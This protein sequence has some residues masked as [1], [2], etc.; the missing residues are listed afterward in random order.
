MSG[1][2]NEHNTATRSHWNSS[3]LTLTQQ[4][5]SEKMAVIESH[6][7]T[8]TTCEGHA[9]L[10]LRS[11]EGED[12]LES[13]HTTVLLGG[14]PVFGHRLEQ[15]VD[16][17]TGY[18][19]DASSLSYTEKHSHIDASHQGLSSGYVTNETSDITPSWVNRTENSKKDPV[20]RHSHGGEV[21]LNSS[22]LS[23]RTGD[24]ISH[25]PVDGEVLEE[26]YDVVLNNAQ[27]DE[28]SEAIN[29]A[30]EPELA[31]GPYR[32]SLQNLLKK[33]QEHRRRQR[34]LRNQAKALKT[35]E[36]GHANEHSL[37]DKENEGC[38]SGDTGKTEFRRTSEN[39][40]DD[41]LADQD[42]QTY[43]QGGESESIKPC[44]VIRQHTDCV[45]LTSASNSMG[46]ANGKASAFSNGPNIADS[47][48]QST[49]AK[50]L[51]QSKGK[52]MSSM[53][54]R[55]CLTGNKKFKNVP[56]PKFCL[57]PVRSKKGSC[58]TASVRKPLVKTPVCNDD[59]ARPNPCGQSKSRTVNLLPAA[60]GGAPLCKSMDQA[61]QIAQLELNL[62]S[63]KVL[64]SDL[65]STLAE[66]QAHNP[67]EAANNP[68]QTLLSDHESVCDGKSPCVVTFSETMQQKVLAKDHGIQPGNKQHEVP[69]RVTSLVQ[70]MRAPEAFCT[71]SGSKQLSERTAVLTNVNNQL[72]ERKNASGD[73]KKASENTEDSLNGSSLN[74]SY[75][76]DTPS[77]L[78]SQSGPRGKQ[79]ALEL[80][81][82]EGMSRV[83]RRLQMNIVDGS[84]EERPQSSRPKGEMTQQDL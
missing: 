25:T 60:E 5:P 15:A 34:L 3:S 83:K 57:S 42:P 56:T 43:K 35:S 13:S 50:S 26:E 23:T 68:Q 75:D 20:G 81:G 59:K 72:E 66:S 55:P 65:E 79:L 77:G 2:K 30:V 8:S 21:V 28:V 76:V 58:A 61:K 10:S 51:Y 1:N 33:S 29:L 44:D 82:Q 40:V 36:A 71:I 32:M 62:S 16:M 48:T 45:N 24:I 73:K 67:T 69:Q 64:I 47:P 22:N 49:S 14:L 84:D 38:L 9:D 6:P 52:K 12:S 41:H 7:L 53:L 31:E 11:F 17:N 70:K 37:S 80:N 63:L 18:G 27:I 19:F 78:W 54:P 74:R 4:I 39:Q 46:C